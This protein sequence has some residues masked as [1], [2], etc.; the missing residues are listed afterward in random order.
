LI[1]VEA[2]TPPGT[3]WQLRSCE[4]INCEPWRL[5]EVFT[6]SGGAAQRILD[7]RLIS[8]SAARFY[9]LAPF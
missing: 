9:Q 6:N 2:M 8:P 1:V 7:D 4:S 3:I 5:L